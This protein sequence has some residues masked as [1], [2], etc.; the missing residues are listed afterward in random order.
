MRDG[1]LRGL[2]WIRR[3]LFRQVRVDFRRNRTQ[4]A[5]D[6]SWTRQYHE[7]GFENTD[8][9]NRES[10]IPKGD[11]SRKRTII[12][13]EDTSDLNLRDGRAVATRGLIIDVDDGERV[14]PCTVHS[15]NYIPHG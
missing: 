11:M 14:W 13:D 4:P 10:L 2:L 9:V 1:G 7:H 12:E 8:T 5:R 3:P 15:C 6:K